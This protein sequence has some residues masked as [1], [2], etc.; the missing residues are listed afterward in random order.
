MLAAIPAWMIAVLTPA[1]MSAV[2]T[3]SLVAKLA[4]GPLYVI[5]AN[6]L[7]GKRVFTIGSPTFAVVPSKRVKLLVTR[8]SRKLGLTAVAELASVA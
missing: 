1:L 3:A 5:Q 2:L 6:R 8:R 4:L 7:S